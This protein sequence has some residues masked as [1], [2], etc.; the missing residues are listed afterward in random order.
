MYLKNL[1][2][3]NFKNYSQCETSFSEKV[4]CFFGKNGSGK[5]NLLD[6]IYYMSFCKSNFNSID[7]EN[8]KH[9]NDFFVIQ[10]N[11]SIKD[12]D[13]NVYCGV[14]R[15]FRKQFKKNKKEYQKLSEHIGLIPLVMI[16]PEDI[17][18]I[19]G[20][21]EERRKYIDSVISQYDKSYLELLINYQKALKHRNKLLKDIFD[22][23]YFDPL[24]IEIWD[25][26]LNTY[27]TKIFE[28]RT[29]FIKTLI[30]V[31][32]KYYNY[33]AENGEIISLNYV[34]QL[35]ETEF[36]EGLKK[37]FEKDRIVGYTT[38]GIHKDD[39][40][41]NLKN[42]HIKKI[43]SQGQQKTYLVAL[44]LAQFDFIKNLKNSKP[45][46]LLDDIF[47]KLDP[48]RVKQ[49]IKLV[50]DDEFGQIFITDKSEISLM[51]IFSDNNIEHKV[52]LVS[53]GNII[54]SE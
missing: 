40:E 14:K 18:L 9:E 52:F 1:T 30:P 8:I 53:D 48:D 41:L 33:I 16:S 20:G 12:E 34:S 10:G 39:L 3:L 47:D 28:I 15:D 26:Q 37:S 5:T 42:H 45:I 6:A 44:K 54:E 29:E 25:E 4:N 7:T 38:F 51:K 19:S 36:L 49:I 21:S 31:F 43:G 17:V 50:A 11:Y 46:L 23:K 27:G 2:L 32:Q 22:T 13:Y 24:S 35:F